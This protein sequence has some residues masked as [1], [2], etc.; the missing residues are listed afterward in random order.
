MPVPNEE[1]KQGQEELSEII[2]RDFSLKDVRNILEISDSQSRPGGPSDV[3]G[4]L[5]GSLY[6]REKRGFTS[7]K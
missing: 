1:E 2:Q 3:H 5:D 6:W 7:C 4:T